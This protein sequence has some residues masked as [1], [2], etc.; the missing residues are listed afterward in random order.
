MVSQQISLLPHLLPYGLFSKQQS[1]FS[2]KIKIQNLSSRPCMV[3]P[4][5]PSNN[6]L[7]PPTLVDRKS[8][9]RQG[10]LPCYY[11]ITLETIQQS[12]QNFSTKTQ[13]VKIL[14]FASP[15][16]I[17]WSSS[18]LPLQHKS[19]YHCLKWAMSRV[20]CKHCKQ[21]F[22]FPLQRA[23]SQGQE[24]EVKLGTL[25][26]WLEERVEFRWGT[27]QRRRVKFHVRHDEFEVTV[28]ISSL[29]FLASV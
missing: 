15:G 28:T 4:T 1:V 20:T 7:H 12:W 27:S 19:S 9:Q 17:F 11:F 14:G 13:T 5:A 21:G 23:E 2:F 3:S 24:K 6:P 26:K 8:A 22:V 10:I 25:K 18:A 16:A 29:T